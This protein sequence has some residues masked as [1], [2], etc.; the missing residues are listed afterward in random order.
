MLNPS[1]FVK[2]T[3]IAF[4]GKWADS[5]ISSILSS[6]LSSTLIIYYTVLFTIVLLPFT[7]INPWESE[8]DAYRNLIRFFKHFR[9]SYIGVH[10]LLLF[11]LFILLI[12]IHC[13][14]QNQFNLIRIKINLDLAKDQNNTISQLTEKFKSLLNPSVLFVSFSSK[15]N[16]H[17]ALIPT[18]TGI[19]QMLIVS[20][21]SMLL[22]I[23]GVIISLGLALVPFLQIDN[24][25]A[26]PI[27][28]MKKSW[29]LMI[30]K[31]TQIF[32]VFVYSL[33][34]LLIG[35]ITCGIGFIWVLPFLN[36]L[37][38]RYYLSIDE[39]KTISEDKCIFIKK[40]SAV[41]L[42]LA[43]QEKNKKL[44]NFGLILIPLLAFL[45]MPNYISIVL[46][47][48][49]I[50][51]M[52]IKSTKSLL[53]YFAPLFIVLSTMVLIVGGPIGHYFSVYSQF[54]GNEDFYITLFNVIVTNCLVIY[55][56][57]VYFNCL[58]LIFG[59]HTSEKDILIDHKVFKYFNYF[60]CIMAILSIS[61]GVIGN[62][63]KTKSPKVEE[64]SNSQN[65]NEIDES[66]HAEIIENPISTG[67][68]NISKNVI[69][70]VNDL[71]NYGEFLSST[72]GVEENLYFTNLAEGDLLIEYSSN[73]GKRKTLGLERENNTNEITGIYFTN[74]PNEI[75]KITDIDQNN[76]K[77]NL[78]SPDG[79][80]Q[81]FIA[82]EH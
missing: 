53:I 36:F 44:I 52:K 32:M 73:N 60:I 10:E 1:E 38:A 62:L 69:K 70:S 4:K 57:F 26:R 46:S 23:P 28:L 45:C 37:L 8:Y 58:A 67:E 39:D 24:P 76:I 40:E 47:I 16:F 66:N 61:F 7:L 43:N 22:V 29:S 79:T 6:I 59:N 19:L 51:L 50:V 55:I 41:Q 14:I 77:F 18:F 31:K 56:L 42:D 15:S 65:A 17:K 72:N 68:N 74:K 82:I 34:L 5:F 2:D 12:C 25:N 64:T 54:D 78:I 71:T 20:I 9:F 48:V 80:S 35:I 30:N 81:E 13:I 75:Y 49:S 21:G 33:P 11:L 3:R 63:E 27:A